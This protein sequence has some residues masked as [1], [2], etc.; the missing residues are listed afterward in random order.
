MQKGTRVAEKHISQFTEV[1]LK[2]IP[3]YRFTKLPKWS[4]PTCYIY[5]LHCPNLP[6]KRLMWQED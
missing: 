3:D 1:A 6:T 5:R 2:K 4:Y